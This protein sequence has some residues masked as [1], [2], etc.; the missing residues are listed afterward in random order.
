[1]EKHQLIM[2]PLTSEDAEQLLGYIEIILNEVYVEPKRLDALAKKRKE[3][4]EKG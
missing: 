2:E 1:M 4:E 3:L